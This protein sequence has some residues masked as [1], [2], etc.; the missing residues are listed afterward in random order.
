MGIVSDASG[1]TVSNASAADSSVLVTLMAKAMDDDERRVRERLLALTSSEVREL[2]LQVPLEG[3]PA[4]YAHLWQDDIEVR[5]HRRGAWV[6][7][8]SGAVVLPIRAGSSFALRHDRHALRLG[9]VVAAVAA[10]GSG[11]GRDV[12]LAPVDGGPSAAIG[13]TP[14]SGA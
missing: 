6:A 4:A 3:D 2:P 12:P 11:L 10:A 9:V 8:R 7:T 5:E 13:Q 14:A 1:F